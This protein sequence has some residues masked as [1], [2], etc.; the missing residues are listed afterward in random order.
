MGREITI[1]HANPANKQ[2]II[3][4]VDSPGAGGANHH[5]HIAG[6]NTKTNASCPF[7]SRYGSPADHA[8]ILFQNGPIPEMGVNGVT[9]EALLAILADRL[10]AF[11]EG[12]YA[13]EENARAF[14]HVQMALA[15]L[16]QRTLAREARG[17]EG[18]H[19]V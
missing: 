14:G 19:A 18:T 11:Q 2:L 1:H 15:A 17:V 8:T 16:H 4:A 9:Q 12:P 10:A 13:C 5:Y 7:Q 6:L 3:H